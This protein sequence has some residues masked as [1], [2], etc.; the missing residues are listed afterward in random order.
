MIITMNQLTK[1]E[2]LHSY[3]LSR[4]REGRIGEISVDNERSSVTR[5]S[6]F[7]LKKN[8][9]PF[10]E[11]K[12]RADFSVLKYHCSVSSVNHLVFPI[13]HPYLHY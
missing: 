4:I 2:G 7:V 10:I 11:G 12:F 3:L 6:K 5:N 8:N 1:E 13:W 9:L